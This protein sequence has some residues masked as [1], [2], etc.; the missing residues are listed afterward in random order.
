MKKR[1]CSAGAKK[2]KEGGEKGQKI[3][4]G[5]PRSFYYLKKTFPLNGAHH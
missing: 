2:K 1:L 3:G 5:N 4:R